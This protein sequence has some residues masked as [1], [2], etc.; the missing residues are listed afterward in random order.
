MTWKDKIRKASKY[1]KLGKM[2][3]DLLEAINRSDMTDEYMDKKMVSDGSDGDRSGEDDSSM[4]ELRRALV[5][6]SGAIEE[7][8]NLAASDGEWDGSSGEPYPYG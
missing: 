2:A 8:D 7:L 5:A 3:E 4:D 6:F 1:S